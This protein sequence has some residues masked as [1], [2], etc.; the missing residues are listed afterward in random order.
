MS[1]APGTQLSP[2][3]M[4]LYVTD[5]DADKVYVVSMIPPN[6]PP[7]SGTPT[8]NPPNATTGTV[9][10]TVGVTDT[11]K[12]TLTYTVDR[13]ADEGHARPQ[14]QRHVHLHADLHGPARC[15]RL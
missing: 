13:E 6:N 5:Y 7:T 10:G 2:D 4:K 15:L 9:T 3:G 14:G 12:D 11:D 8:F 1:V